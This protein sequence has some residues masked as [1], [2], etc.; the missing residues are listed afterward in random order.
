M[1]GDARSTKLM[2]RSGRPRDVWSYGV[3]LLEAMLAPEARVFHLCA[4]ESNG[5]SRSQRNIAVPTCSLAG[6]AAGTRF[7]GRFSASPAPNPKPSL[8]PHP[9]HFT[10]V[11]NL[12]LALLPRSRSPAG[13]VP[14]SRRDI[15]A[16]AAVE[17]LV[18]RLALDCMAV[19]AELRPTFVQIRGRLEEELLRSGFE[20]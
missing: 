19:R 3:C 9:N 16:A 15:D 11:L 10:H 5:A 18:A 8:H 4:S 6:A 7:C 1:K 2:G 17:P 12:P 13:F 20:A 14:A